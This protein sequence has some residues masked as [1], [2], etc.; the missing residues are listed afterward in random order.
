MSWSSVLEQLERWHR[1][2]DRGAAQDAFAFL[3]KELRREVP[4][5]GA[6][7]EEALLDVLGT[8][9]A[10]PLPAG[11]QDPRAYLV[12][13]LRMRAID[14]VRARQRRREQG[15]EN[16]VLPEAVERS[17]E[18]SPS[19]AVSARERDEANALIAARVRR[20]VV[21]LAIADRVA[22]KLCEAPEWL[23]DEEIA[24]L[25]SRLSQTSI[26]VRAAISR[27]RD[28][29]DLTRIYDPGEDDPHDPEARRKRME[30][31]R[32]RSNRI[33]ERIARLMS[34]GA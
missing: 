3:E 12:A 21:R 9:V 27:A 4:N 23:D 31:F 1:D 6:E 16:I 22:F 33:A 15:I 2:Q 14:R 5:R 28:M 20:A 19:D 7:A 34:E 10:K 24:W 26:E 25:A 30:R 17:R 18:L 32:K 13:A 8:L 11:V 29:H